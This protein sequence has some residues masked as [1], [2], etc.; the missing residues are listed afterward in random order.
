MTLVIVLGLA[1]CN[2]I[3][4]KPA[5]AA[6]V[7]D[8][9]EQKVKQAQVAKETRSS[10]LQAQASTLNMVGPIYQTGF[11]KKAEAT[12]ALSNV[13][14]YIQDNPSK[15]DQLT[16][17]SLS[18][19]FSSIKLNGF[20]LGENQFS[21]VPA[22]FNVGYGDEAAL[23]AVFNVALAA[24]NPAEIGFYID[25]QAWQKGLVKL[26]G[27]K[28]IKAQGK[29]RNSTW[30]HYTLDLTGQG[31]K[32]K[33]DALL[34]MSLYAIASDIREF[35]SIDRDAVMKF[36]DKDYVVER[37]NGD[38]R[39]FVYQDRLKLIDNEIESNVDALDKE[40]VLSDT[41][42]A[43]S[44][45]I[46]ETQSYVTVNTLT[47]YESKVSFLS[48]NN[49]NQ[50]TLL[51]ESKQW[52]EYAKKAYYL[53]KL[54]A[55]LILT[56]KF[57][58]LTQ[59]DVIK[60]KINAQS[61]HSFHFIDTK[62]Q[63]IYIDD[64]KVFLLDLIKAETRL[65]PTLGHVA[66]LAVSE[67][68]KAIYTLSSD[69]TLSYFD[70]KTQRLSLIK[71]GVTLSGMTVCGTSNSLLYWHE[72]QASMF[73]VMSK[74]DQ[75]IQFSTPLS[76]DLITGDCAT[77]EAKFLL[78]NRAGDIRQFD[79]VSYQEIA[80][81]QGDYDAYDQLNSGYIVRYLKGNEF[82]YGGKK[83]L[84]IRPSTTE[85]E[86]RSDYKKRLV[87]INS[88]RSWLDKSSI[89]QVV[90]A[91]AIP[92]SDLELY[93][94]LFNKKLTSFEQKS[95]FLSFLN[96]ELADPLLVANKP[97]LFNAL[98]GGISVVEEGN[99]MLVK[100]A[101]EESN[102]LF[103]TSTPNWDHLGFQVDT[104][105]LGMQGFKPQIYAQLDNSQLT[106]D[107]VS[108]TLSENNDWLVTTLTNG[109]INLESLSSDIKF[110]DTFQAHTNQVTAAAFSADAQRLATSGRDGLIKIWQL[111]APKGNEEGDWIELVKE[112]KGY[113]GNVLDL[114]F[115]NND[116]LIST[117]SDQ[118]IKLWNIDNNGSVQNEMLGH[119]D[120]VRFA[121]YDKSLNQIIS[122]SD[123]AS[124]RVWDLKKAEQI[125]SFKG[126]D[127]FVA[128]YDV[129][130]NTLAYSKNNQILLKNIVS[131]NTVGRIQFVQAPLHI[132]LGFNAKVSY[133]IY[134]D[135]I[136]VFKVASGEKIN[137]I[138]LT[139]V[140]GIKQVFSSNDSH[141]LY[142]MTDQ[143]ASV[144][145]MGQYALFGV[146][147]VLQ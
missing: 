79:S 63:A 142:L 96:E 57:L 44:I 134:A 114:D 82:I 116:M 110:N 69:K 86:I 126:G 35:A 62:R 131:G 72:K 70:A 29:D 88:A 81:I 93:Q 87:R 42:N 50:N 2:A 9:L 11:E 125:K 78:M 34:R 37:A 80:Q 67:D 102:R 33:V 53:P 31:N 90:F 61:I 122:A 76:D 68:A 103:T 3:E 28:T 38:T 147:N 25:A 49:A 123:D 51:W 144:L 26:Q 65:L 124:V 113:A 14:N 6:N 95:R 59:D 120:S 10:W 46:D 23:N 41:A 17:R 77:H 91:E 132:E 22:I 13:L 129:N 36:N 66:Q 20:E 27:Y 97:S 74:K 92:E 16:Q 139:N 106:A 143:E 133:L 5:K 107:I 71:K 99:I 85:S 130:S 105:F 1:G 108:M 52:D 15:L 137:E 40:R 128:A 119:T 8:E 24:E 136:A 94:T 19:Q 21:Y 54:N 138:A 112:L 101:T 141:D 135:H 45:Y 39:A 104:L 140:E 18:D 109:E 30:F 146:E 75:T 58:T 64:N 55:T 12:K 4:E 43:R 48:L 111:Y 98:S 73:E 127:D 117:G 100:Q 118:T 89:R 115:V 56:D 145:N 7:F 83:D 60:F 84:K 47:D 121:L 32:A